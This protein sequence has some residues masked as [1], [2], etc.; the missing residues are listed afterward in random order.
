V[1]G[2]SCGLLDGVILRRSCGEPQKNCVRIACMLP[3]TR[4]YGNFYITGFFSPLL[5]PPPLI[6][7][8]YVRHLLKLVLFNMAQLGQICK[9]KG[10]SQC[11]DCHKFDKQEGS[12]RYFR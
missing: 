5:S 6:V 3:E 1:E 12:T 4:F 10:L 9:L 7:K 11:V 2:R 8:C